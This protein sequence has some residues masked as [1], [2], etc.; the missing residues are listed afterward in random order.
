[1][2]TLQDYYTDDDK[3]SI[4]AEAMLCDE[5]KEMVLNCQVAGYMAAMEELQENY[6]K[7][8]VIYLILVEQLI[9]RQRYDYTTNGIK[10]MISRSHKILEEMNDIDGK[11]IEML[12]VAL[13][14]KDMDAEVRK[15]WQKFLGN[16]DDLPN[17][18]DL[19]NFAMPLAKH[20][21]IIRGIQSQ[22]G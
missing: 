19:K 20:L 9:Q 13:V 2:T 17:I 15:E 14:V 5:S 7:K 12:A 21:G 8:S 4:L 10:E 6:G 16:K 11:D 1:M 3:V 18:S 22:L